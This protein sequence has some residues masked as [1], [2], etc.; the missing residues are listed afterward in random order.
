MTSAL[1][2][3]TYNWPEALE[4]V[5]KSVKLQE[6]FPT[7]VIIADDGSSSETKELIEAFAKEFP[8]PLKHVWHE[9]KGFRK[10]GILNLAISKTKA[11]YII[12]LDGDCI[13]H[14]KFI[15][16]HL[17][18]VESNTYLYGS[19]V[20]VQ[21]DFLSIL[22]KKKIV[23]FSYFSKGIK[24]RNR[25]LHI[26]FLGSLIYKKSNKLSRKLRG[27]NLSYWK[28]DFIKVNGYNE[29]M[30]GW[31]REDSELIIRIINSGIL[32]KRMKFKAIIYHIWHKE[33]SKTKLNIN[34]TIQQK[35][36]EE[37]RV[38]CENGIDKYLNERE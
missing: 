20:N 23:K 2:I 14:K 7:E 34:D 16:D 10:S 28:S 38:W 6:V 25:N 32:G 22:F 1:I 27:C 30:T 37:R 33:S 4:L 13:M 12:Q 15:K 24:K 8:V 31:G 18:S 9:D 21:E 11:D 35:T 36:I 3:T 5:L 26:P 19:R 17:Q 29:N